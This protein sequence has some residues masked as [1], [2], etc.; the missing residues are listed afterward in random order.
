M[1]VYFCGSIRGGTQDVPI[2]AQLIQHLKGYGV[3]LTEHVGD[4]AYTSKLEEKLSD[5]EIWIQDMEWLHQSK[6]VVAEVTVVSM[7]VGYELGIAESLGLPILCLFRGKKEQLSA[8]ISGNRK[9][10]VVYYTEI[11][12]AINAID[13]FMKHHL[14]N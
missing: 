14:I 2:Y 4:P 7:G 9:L 10:Q 6:V 1:N 8:M 12:E 11:H 3:V 13:E 5:D